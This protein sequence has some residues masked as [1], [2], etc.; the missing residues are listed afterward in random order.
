[1]LY[2]L[3]YGGESCRKADPHRDGPQT[4]A[5]CHRVGIDRRTHLLA[6]LVVRDAGVPGRRAP[7]ASRALSSVAEMGSDTIELASCR[8]CRDSAGCRRRM[9]ARSPGGVRRGEFG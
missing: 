1:M 7:P 6:D 4:N 3:S 2:P 9:A 8:H 5:A